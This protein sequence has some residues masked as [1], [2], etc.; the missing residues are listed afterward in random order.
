MRE[1]N[2]GCMDSSQAEQWR[3][4]NGCERDNDMSLRA[5]RRGF[6]KGSPNLMHVY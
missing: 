3:S 5:A 2:E 4:S 6:D 1:I